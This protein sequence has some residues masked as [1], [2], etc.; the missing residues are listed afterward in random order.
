MKI[1]IAIITFFRSF[2]YLYDRFLA[3]FYKR[4]MRSCGTDV[5]IRPSSSD[6]KGLENMTVGHHVLIPKNAVVYCTGAPL[7][8]GNYVLFGPAPSVLTGDHRTDV[9]GEFMY[10]V[11][12]KSAESD[13]PV[14][15]GDDVWVGAHVTIL[16][17][18]ELGRGS[19]VA[20][21]AVVTRSFPPYSV[22]GGVPAKLIRQRFTP[23]EI[24]KHEKALYG[25]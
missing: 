22:I 7:T 3:Y 20:A 1:N 16:K 13:L 12:E 9:V 24:E 11:R 17:G 18:V 4:S 23:E 8:I 15:I 2:S 10:E 14:V 19:V 25:H 21:G 5:Y 6:F